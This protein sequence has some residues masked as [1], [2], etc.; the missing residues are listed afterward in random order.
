MSEIAQYGSALEAAQYG[1]ALERALYGALIDSPPTLD[2]I[3]AR[4]VVE[5]QQLTFTVTASDPEST[6]TLSVTNLPPGATFDAGTGVFEWTPGAGASATSPYSV[7]FGAD[8]GF[9]PIVTEV[10]EITVNSANQAPV[11]AN[12]IPNQT[13]NEGEAFTFQFAADTFSDP[14]DDPLTYTSD[15]AGW[16]SFSAPTRTFTGTPLN[17]DVGTVTVEVTADD[18]N[19]GTVSTTFDIIV[20]AAANTGAVFSGTLSFNGVFGDRIIGTTNIYDANGLS[21][22]DPYSISVQGDHGT[23][24]I[25]SFGTGGTGPHPVSWEYTPTDPQWYGTDSF[26]LSATDDNS[27][28]ASQVINILLRGP[29]Q[30]AEGDRLTI[31]STLFDAN[32]IAKIEW[33]WK[34]NMSLIP[35]ENQ[36]FITAENIGSVYSGHAKVTDNLGNVTYFDTPVTDPVVAREI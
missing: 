9:N 11:V 26:T 17:G 22:A 28:T 36:Q 10:V 19:S 31:L 15:A 24:V 5:G 29:N 16:L 12:Q 32:G 25:G 35:N 6:P 1:T 13:A 23:V 18:G 2:P 27:N 21:S 3:G 33:S 8:D 4:N 20:N 14:N 34:E 30:P 7:T